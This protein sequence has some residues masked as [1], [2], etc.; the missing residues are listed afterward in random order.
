MQGPSDPALRSP[1]NALH[2]LYLLAAEYRGVDHDESRLHVDAILEPPAF[3]IED[4]PARFQRGPEIASDRKRAE[5]PAD[6]EQSLPQRDQH[7]TGHLLDA[8]GNLELEH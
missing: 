4:H 7:V 2:L 3:E 8:L 6:L 1:V 5:R